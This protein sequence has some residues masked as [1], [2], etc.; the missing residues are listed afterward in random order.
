MCD[1]HSPYCTQ[2]SSCVRASRKLCSSVRIVCTSCSAPTCASR[3][4][5]SGIRT[6]GPIGTLRCASTSPT[7]KWCGRTR[8]TVTPVTVSPERSAWMMGAAPR[9][10]GSR[11]AW[12]LIMPLCRGRKPKSAASSQDGWKRYQSIGDYKSFYHA[13][14]NRLHFYQ[15]I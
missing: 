9:H 13:T 4:C 12:T 7:S 6:C 1:N 15:S 5:S 11:L 10:R 2:L 8:M 14:E 3:V